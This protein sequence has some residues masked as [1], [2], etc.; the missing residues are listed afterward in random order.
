MLTSSRSREST[1]TVGS[2]IPSVFEGA[3]IR[4]AFGV[5]DMPAEVAYYDPETGTEVLRLA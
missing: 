4:V 2:I 1:L 3:S 5:I